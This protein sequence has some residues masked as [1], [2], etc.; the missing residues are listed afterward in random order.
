VA[1]NPLTAILSPEVRVLGEIDLSLYGL[2]QQRARTTLHTIGQ[3]LPISI[4]NLRPRSA[5][6]TA[7]QKKAQ[8]LRSLAAM[9]S[10]MS[11]GTEFAIP[12]FGLRI[13]SSHLKRHL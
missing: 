2:G 4:S 11:A 7:K 10:S 13:C 3:I 9:P 6:A 1:H 12:I 8:Q 5:L